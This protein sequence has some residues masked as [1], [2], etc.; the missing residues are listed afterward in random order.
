MF[1][2][3]VILLS[4]DYTGYLVVKTLVYFSECEGIL[5]GLI[6]GFWP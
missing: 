5:F 3:S 4:G 2:F 1:L 6:L